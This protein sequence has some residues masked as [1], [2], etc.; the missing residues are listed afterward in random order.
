[1]VG[2]NRSTVGAVFAAALA[3]KSNCVIVE[4]NANC[5]TVTPSVKVGSILRFS[6]DVNRRVS[7]STH[8]WQCTTEAFNDGKYDRIVIL[9]DE[10]TADRQV[11]NFNVP[12]YTFNLAGYRAAHSTQGV[13]N[14]YAFAGFSDSCFQVMSLIESAGK[15]CWPW[16]VPAT[17]VVGDDDE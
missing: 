2:L 3:R 17:I 7:G 10:Q 14:S 12:V 9:T 11:Q 15:D 1:V 8:T 4:Y 16:E 6:D 13:K 5:R